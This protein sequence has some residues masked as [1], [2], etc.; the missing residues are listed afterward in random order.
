M[1]VVRSAEET[2]TIK[3]FDVSQLIPANATG[4]AIVVYRTIVLKALRETLRNS[5]I[6]KSSCAGSGF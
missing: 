5:M 4:V 2:T 1:A 3:L 6:V